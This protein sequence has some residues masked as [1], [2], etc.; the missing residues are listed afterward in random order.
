MNFYLM[1]QRHEDVDMKKIYGTTAKFER[2]Y[3]IYKKLKSLTTNF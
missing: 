2:V 3:T 1:T